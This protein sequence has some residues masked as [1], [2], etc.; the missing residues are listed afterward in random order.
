VVW[1]LILQLSFGYLVLSWEPGERFFSKL[2]DVFTALLSFST[3]GAKFIFASLGSVGPGSLQDYLTRLG[4]PSA[5]PAVQQAISYGTV[6]GFTFA[7]QVLPTIIFFSALLSI[8]Y[9]LGIMQKVVVL[10]AKIMA[11]TMNVSGAESLSNSA[12]IFVGQTPTLKR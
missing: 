5:D 6:P 9:Y 11:K 1:G 7:F 8:L 10:F 4:K 3:E 12:N 2:N